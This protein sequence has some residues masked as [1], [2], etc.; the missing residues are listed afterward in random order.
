MVIAIIRAPV[1]RAPVI[2]DSDISVFDRHDDAEDGN[3]KVEVGTC[4]LTCIHGDDVMA[5]QHGVSTD[6]ME[7]FQPDGAEQE[8]GEDISSLIDEAK[9]IMQEMCMLLHDMYCFIVLIKTNTCRAE[10]VVEYRCGLFLR[11][12]QKLWGFYHETHLDDWFI[13][14]YLERELWH[15]P[16]GDPHEVCEDDRERMNYLADYVNNINCVDDAKWRLLVRDFTYIHCRKMQAVLS[17]TSTTSLLTLVRNM[18]KVAFDLLS[19]SKISLTTSGDDQL[20]SAH[21][22]QIHDVV[23]KMCNNMR[24]LREIIDTSCVPS[25]YNAKKMFNHAAL[26]CKKLEASL[27]IECSRKWIYSSLALQLHKDVIEQCLV[28]DVDAFIQAYQELPGILENY[29]SGSP[30]I[31]TANY[32]LLPEEEAE[33]NLDGNE[34]KEEVGED[35]NVMDS[36]SLVKMFLMGVFVAMIMFIITNTKVAMDAE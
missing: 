31:D 24:C 5:Q 6:M 7:R 13:L 8:G 4:S 29:I 23:W 12:L 2:D 17:S 20:D 30:S 32:L 9:L 11:K 19:A 26:L 35:Q 15:E 1:I 28:N 3:A 33:F 14:K 27:M 21:D 22:C 18:L 10:N 25:T 16:H 34:S 36:I